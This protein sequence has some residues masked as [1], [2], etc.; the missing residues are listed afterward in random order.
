MAGLCLA[1]RGLIR[2]CRIFMPWALGEEM[3]F[4]LI[5]ALGT[6]NQPQPNMKMARLARH[7]R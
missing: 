6:L 5:T 3:Y 7:V 1:L 4:L 2:G